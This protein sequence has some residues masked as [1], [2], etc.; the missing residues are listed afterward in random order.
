M[1]LTQ[2][3]SALLLLGAAAGCRYA[4]PSLPPRPVPPRPTIPA[5]PDV[6]SVRLTS[7]GSSLQHEYDVTLTKGSDIEAL[8]DWLKQVDWSPSRA[9]DLSNVGL[10]EVGQITVTMKNGATH[11][12]GLSGGRVIVNRWEWPADTDRL[13]AIAKQAGAKIP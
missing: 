9:N 2:V 5:A 6:A 12:F 8:V 13:A 7:I 11:S 1:R 10:A 3:L 4:A